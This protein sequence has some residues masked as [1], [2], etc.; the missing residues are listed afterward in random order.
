MGL[1]EVLAVG[2][3]TLVEVGDRVETEPVDAHVEPERQRLE[4]RLVDLGVV[5]VQVRLVAVEAV[6]EVLLADRVPRPVRRLGVDE[7]D[8]GVLVELV[9]VGPDVEV[10]VGP[11]GILPAGLEPRVR[12][13]RVVHDEVDDHPDAAGVGGVEEVVEVVDGADLGKDVGVV[14]DVVA[15]VTQRRGHERRHPQ[16]VHA[17]PLEVVELLGQAVEVADAVAVAVLERPDQHLVEDRCLEPVG[18]VVRQPLR[19]LSLVGVV[20]GRDLLGHWWGLRTV[21]MWAGSTYGSSRT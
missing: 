10:A 15:T 18:R 12:V 8:A 14:G 13:R 2:A 6:P 1:L 3:G 16:T 11:L 19:G 21:K 20:G 7:D 9:G 17:E 5:E 4:H